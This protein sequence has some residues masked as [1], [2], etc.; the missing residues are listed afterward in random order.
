MTPPRRH[1][2]RGGVWVATGGCRATWGEWV[3]AEEHV[4]AVH[5]DACK[6]HA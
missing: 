2:R 4:A 1:A 3:A 6:M 5:V